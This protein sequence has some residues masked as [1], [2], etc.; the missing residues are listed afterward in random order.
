MPQ[1]VDI[2]VPG[3]CN[4]LPEGFWSAI[5]V[6]L[7]KPHVLNKRLCGVKETESKDLRFPFDDPLSEL[8]SD[9]LSFINSGLRQAVFFSDLL[10]ISLSCLDFGRQQVTF[11]P[12]EEDAE[13]Q[14]SLKKGNIYQIQ[15]CHHHRE[16]W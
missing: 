6:W 1:L 2:K 3:E 5:D 14:V 11:L 13:G 4:T 7:K 10:F 16:E 12:F 15:L 9:V 8:S